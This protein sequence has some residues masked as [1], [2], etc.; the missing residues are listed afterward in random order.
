M[1]IQQLRPRFLV[2]LGGCISLAVVDLG[3]VFE[4][5]SVKDVFRDVKGVIREA[6]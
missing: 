5:D 1:F 2:F 4:A 3:E 6:E